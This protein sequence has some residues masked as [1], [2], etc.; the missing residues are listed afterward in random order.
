MSVRGAICVCDRVSG[1][2]L[3]ET[4]ASTNTWLIRQQCGTLSGGKEGR[5]SRLAAVCCLCGLQLACWL[6]G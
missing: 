4:G 1:E 6:A 5:T 2:L 3:Q